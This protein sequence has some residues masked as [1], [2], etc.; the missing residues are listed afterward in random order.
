MCSTSPAA[1][2]RLR[3]ARIICRSQIPANVNY[4]RKRS[5]VSSIIAVTF[6]ST[7]PSRDR[8]DRTKGGKTGAAGGRGQPRDR[9]CGDAWLLWGAGGGGN[10]VTWHHGRCTKGPG[11][12][13]PGASQLRHPRRPGTVAVN[14]LRAG[15]SKMRKTF[16]SVALMVLIG[17]ALINSPGALAQGGS[18]SVSK[19]SDKP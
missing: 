14:K 11:L 5:I 10:L 19:N 3:S 8:D 17:A 6:I 7:R 12:R 18:S 9:K 4:P 13:G 16:L 15:R 2:A 1:T